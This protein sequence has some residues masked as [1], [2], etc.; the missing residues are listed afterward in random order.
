[1]TFA[2]F[3]AIVGLYIWAL[4]E[5]K[6]RF[7]WGDSAWL[8]VAIHVNGVPY[9]NWQGGPESSGQPI[10]PT[11]QLSMRPP[12]FEFAT[13]IPGTYPPWY[14]PAYWNEGVRITRSPRDWAAAVKHQI[15]LYAILLI[16]QLPL[17]F[18]FAVLFF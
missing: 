12:I 13:P 14:D 6:G 15:R 17:L 10:H 4:S 3:A 9:V 7:T 16:L 1:M 18:A 8:N 11:R 2:I 5:A